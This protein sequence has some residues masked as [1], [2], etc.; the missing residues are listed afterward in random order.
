[1]PCPVL[2]PPVGGGASIPRCKW[3]GMVVRTVRLDGIIGLELIGHSQRERGK[4]AIRK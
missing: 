2:S 4:V 3:F 1:M